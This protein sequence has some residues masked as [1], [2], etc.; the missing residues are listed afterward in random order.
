MTGAKV[1]WVERNV[2]GVESEVSVCE[3]RMGVSSGQGV[4]R[5]KKRQGEKVGQVPE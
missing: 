5:I 3:V 4:C 2:S 1:E